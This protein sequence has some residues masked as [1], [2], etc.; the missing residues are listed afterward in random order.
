MIDWKTIL[1][2]FDDKPTLLQWLK[3]VEK[4]LQNAS[5]EDVAIKTTGNSTYVFEFKFADGSTVTSSPINFLKE[6]SGIE[7]VSD[8]IVGTQTITT[9]RVNYID[10][11]SD[12]FSVAAENGKD[13]KAGK[14]ISSFEDINNAIVGTKT[15]TTIRAHYTDGTTEDISVAAENGKNGNDGKEGKAGKGV[16]RFEAISNE[17]SGTKTLTT[18]RAHYTDGTTGD[19][20]V[21]AENGKGIESI[22]NVSNEIVGNQT[23]TTVRAHYTDGTTGDFSV[24]AQNG[25]GGGTNIYMHKIAGI[26]DDS[27]GSGFNINFLSSESTEIKSVDE[28][29]QFVSRNEC[30][31]FT[32][33]SYPLVY[34][35]IKIFDNKIQVH[36][37]DIAKGTAIIGNVRQFIGDEV[38]TV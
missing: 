23:V 22:S 1:S 30:Y 20:N 38:L 7:K 2:S 28:F 16:S 27:A 6:I 18:V 35:D 3:I 13:G 5:L 34:F 19:F 21:A 14:G 15:V 17:I 26:L 12:D 32:G 36:G 8:A 9:L 29:F 4:A 37:A 25:S 33:D 11:T 10:D 24:Y 31:L